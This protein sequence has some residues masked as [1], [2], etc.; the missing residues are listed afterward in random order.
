MPKDMT[1]EHLAQIE[2]AE[3]KAFLISFYNQ[4]LASTKGGKKPIRVDIQ[5]YDKTISLLKENNISLR[6]SWQS[7]PQKLAGMLGVDAVVRAHVEKARFMSD[8]ASYGIEVGTDLVNFLS[9]YHLQDWIPGGMTTSKEVKAN[10]SIIDQKD[11]SRLWSIS[12]DIES[13]WREKANAII[14]G[15]NHKAAK[16]F[17][18]REK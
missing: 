13:D 6:D 7:D 16:Y 18:Y 2:E 8:L 11:A 17:P 4:L 5:N 14:D 10:Y 15:I 12:Y 3:S 9:N 1:Q